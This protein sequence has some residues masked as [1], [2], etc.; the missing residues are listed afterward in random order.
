M[1]NGM[2]N[3]TKP[4]KK[5]L[6]RNIALGVLFLLLVCVLIHYRGVKA[7]ATVE[8]GSAP[9]AAT[10]TDRE[11]TLETDV[12]QLKTGWHVLILRIGLP[13]P[14]LVH[15]VDT[16]APTAEAVPMTVPLGSSPSP[17]AFVRRIKD[18][19]VVRV[20]FS[21]RPDF[22]TEG[23]RTLLIALEDG[24]HNRVAIPVPIRVRATVPS[25]TIEAGDPLPEVSA[26]L[27]DGVNGAF[28][29]P[30]DPA[31]STEV[32]THAVTVATD[33]GVRSET[34]LIVSDTAAPIAEPSLLCV[35]PNEPIEPEACV[36]NANDATPLTFTFVE[37][38]DEH[39]RAL[40]TVLVRVTDAGGNA[41]DV[42]SKVLIS[43]VTPKPIEA[44]RE[45]LTA[46]DFDN[47]DGQTFEVE[48]FVPDTT[49]LHAITVWVN[50][51]EETMTVSVVDTTPPVLTPTA[52]EET[53]VYVLHDYAPEDFFRA[54]DL[55][56]VTMTF[57]E[58]PDFTVAGTKRI[59]VVARDASGNEAR[60]E[61]YV[62]MRR[63]YQPPHIYGAINR[64]CY[65]GEP[66]SYYAEVYAEDEVD[67]SVEVTVDS[68]VILYQEGVYRVVFRTEDRTGNKAQTECTYTLIQR[69]VTEE[70]LHTLAKSIMD[71]ITT[72]D[73]VNAEKLR[74]IF[75]FVQKRI[76]YANGVNNNY[77][78]W[79]KAAYD[80]YMSGTGDC[81]N[82]YS[83]TRALLD[84]TDI[85]YLSVER[86][87]SSVRRTRHY[88]V[89]VNIGTGWYC[90]DPTWTPK[91]PLNCF[92]WTRAQCSTSRM[93]WYYRYA[94]YPPLA[95]EPF[96]YDAVVEMEKNGLLP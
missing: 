86:V 2:Q 90:F 63:D 85:P 81:Y 45:P 36:R 72:P 31:L 18:A 42:E 9:T 56:D 12:A 35:A 71:E 10:F 29:T 78:D 7:I 11:A 22:Q 53:P 65:V 87:K 41:I 6:A 70:E 66:I 94:D 75:D 67:G 76:V 60:A 38:P 39:S 54:E 62:N 48:P 16:T 50:G 17:D 33:G 30:L 84:E 73:M 20:T 19:D 14:V 26:F 24:S 61:R 51:V 28:L 57:T 68:D 88:W 58:E 37:A 89:H 13:T 32:G 1:G 83:L 93:Y 15:V 34:A 5:H 47:P 52:R 95:T 55:S 25:L 82:I 3:G 40:Q 23:E 8:L 21:D 92:M 44:R 74:A 49:G 46:D 79:R 77:T 4:K 59:T 64:I 91:H 80:G 27:L 69:T 43:N 96:D